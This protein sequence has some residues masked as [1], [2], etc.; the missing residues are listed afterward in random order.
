MFSSAV[1][2]HRH[3]YQ[4]D[5]WLHCRLQHLTQL[6]LLIVRYVPAPFPGRKWRE[7][8]LAVKLTTDAEFSAARHLSGTVHSCSYLGGASLKI[9]R[10]LR[11]AGGAQAQVY[12]GCQECIVTRTYYKRRSRQCSTFFYDQPPL[13]QA[14]T[15]KHDSQRLV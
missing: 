5:A 13:Y 3:A 1:L 9:A 7:L 2:L 15:I 12:G 6:S 14:Y 10:P 11:V 8:Q 4:T